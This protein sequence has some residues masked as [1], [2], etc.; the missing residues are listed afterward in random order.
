MTGNS[1]ANELDGYGGNDTLDGGL[2]ADDMEGGDGDD[3]YIVDNAGD[4]VVE[5]AGEGVDIVKASVTFT[6]AANV[7]NL[8][9]TGTTAINGTGN[10]LD[11]ILVGNSAANTLTGGAGN[12]TLDGG[13]GNDTLVG[14]TG[15]DHYVVDSTSDVV[16][17]SSNQGTDTVYASATFTLGTNVENLI[18][19]GTASINGTGNTANNN[20]TGNAGNNVL[21]GGTGADTMAG[22]LGNDT[23][24]VDNS[25]DV[26]SENANEGT[27][28]VQSSITYTLGANVENL[29]LTGT[30]AINGTGN[31]A[32]NVLVG[33]SGANVL[34]GGAGNDTIDGGAGADTM[35]G[36]MGDDSYVISVATD[37]ITENAGEG[38]DT[39]QSSV[40]YTLG[41]NVENLTLTGTTAINGTGNTLDNILVGNSAA[42]TLTGGAGND[43]LDGGAGNDTLVGGTGDD[44]YVVDS[45]SDVVT[46]NANEGIDTVN[47]AIAYTLSAN[48]ENLTLTGTSAI[49]GTGNASDN[50]LTGNSG[51]NTLTGAAGNDTLDGGAGADKLLG[52][53][54][55]D[56]Y[57]VDNAGDIVTENANE[58]TDT[59]N[60]SISYTL[61]ANV[62]NLTLT[63]MSAINGTGNTLNNVLIGNTGNNVL[64]GGAGADTLQGGQGND[65]L[66]GGVGNDTYIF[67]LGWGNDTLTDYDTAANTDVISF[68]AGITS[69]GMTFQQV[70]NDLICSV[71]D[72]TDSITIKNWYLGSAYQ[73]EQFH[74]A[75]GTT[76]SASQVSGMANSMA[77]AMAMPNQSAISAQLSSVD[78]TKDAMPMSIAAA[79]APTYHTIPFMPPPAFEHDGTSGWHGRIVPSGVSDWLGAFTQI[80]PQ[81]SGHRLIGPHKFGSGAGSHI[82]PS[83]PPPQFID[84]ASP[85]QTVTAASFELPSTSSEMSPP[86]SPG[87]SDPCST[88]GATFEDDSWYQALPLDSS[89]ALADAVVSTEMP[90]PPMPSMPSMP[91]MPPMPSNA[92]TPGVSGGMAHTHRLVEL[93]ASM[94]GANFELGYRAFPEYIHMLTP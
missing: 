51:I 67:A 85:G 12:D 49:N 75:D 34:T 83:E 79:N 90:T 35:I 36:G 9:L 59:I 92:D 62:E 52:G 70:G 24:V 82:I 32:D 91:S 28:L 26:V 54:G 6:L 64:D 5:L 50:V 47:S 81:R 88:Q 45:T 71:L 84:D 4:K 60:S 13:A 48:L 17:E 76:L 53:T 22:G 61:G 40:T 38:I 73:V 80:G 15:D 39:A 18:L 43:T 56:T 41:A 7:E 57:V 11:N 10:T 58:G 20:L 1:I 94:G 21:S 16:T 68:G 37:V 55:N 33:N 74:F 29:T 27:D 89:P 86:V 93:M 66:L 19:T 72:G 44:H 42:N 14:G 31:A 63:G 2:G 8:T 46:E 78:S 3:M 25:G 30:S 23:Y 69:T 77:M 87:S 65:S